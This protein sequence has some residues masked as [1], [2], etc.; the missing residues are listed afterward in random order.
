M[1]VHRDARAP[2]PEKT[3]LLAVSLKV[4]WAANASSCFFVDAI[5]F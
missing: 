3:P 1:R 5:D 2:I 4:F